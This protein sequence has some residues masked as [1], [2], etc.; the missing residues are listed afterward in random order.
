MQA[1]KTRS[2]ARTASTPME[3]EVLRFRS[4]LVSLLGKDEEGA[5][6][7]A[8]VARILNATTKKPQQTFKGAKNFLKELRRV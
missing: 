4:A 1:V 8:F 5:Y 7:P 6:R 2:K 3:A